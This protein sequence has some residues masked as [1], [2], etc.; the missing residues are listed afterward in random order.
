M[1]DIDEL[2]AIADGNIKRKEEIEKIP[3]M[4][5]FKEIEALVELVLPNM[6][7]ESK[8]IKWN[9]HSRKIP[10]SGGEFKNCVC[11]LSDD[12]L[13]IIIDYSWDWIRGQEPNE[14]KV[15]PKGFDADKR[16]KFDVLKQLLEQ[17]GIIIDHEEKEEIDPLFLDFDYNIARKEQI[18][19]LIITVPR[20]KDK[21][22]YIKN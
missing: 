2:F 12:E 15:G 22:S 14:R 13:K 20:Q 19:Y 9:K 8:T 11:T 18:D 21:G 17:D 7:T 4:K 16:I 6:D 3:T 1:R 10:R 5:L